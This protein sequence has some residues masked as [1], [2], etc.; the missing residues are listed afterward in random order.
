M[1]GKFL[2][3]K[4]SVP[5]HARTCPAVDILK[6]TQQGAEQ[7]RCGCRLRC[8]I[9][10]GARWRNLANTMRPYVKLFRPSV[11][12]AVKVLIATFRA[13]VEGLSIFLVT[14]CTCVM[15]YSSAIYYAEILCPSVYTPS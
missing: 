9:D 4:W 12:V 6:A 1:K 8:I 11:A 2:K 5:E 3:R 13:S 14:L 10:R 15:F 7:V